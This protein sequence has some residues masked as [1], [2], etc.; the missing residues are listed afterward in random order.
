MPIPFARPPVRKLDSEK[1]IRI[2]IIITGEIGLIHPVHPS[3]PN[4][5]RRLICLVDI[6]LLAVVVDVNRMVGDLFDIIIT[7]NPRD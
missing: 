3:T 5:I 7:L 2:I 1:I 4:L 6:I